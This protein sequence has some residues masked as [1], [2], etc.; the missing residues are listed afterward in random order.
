MAGDCFVFENVENTK[1]KMEIFLKILKILNKL[2]ICWT[3]PISTFRSTLATGTTTP[4][5]LPISTFGHAL[6]LLGAYWS[7]YYTT[8]MSIML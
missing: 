1:F 6:Q 8:S 2:K 3:F 4:L 7:H 5:S